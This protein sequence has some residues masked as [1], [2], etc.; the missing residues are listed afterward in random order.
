MTLR[1]GRFDVLGNLSV[2][3][4]AARDDRAIDVAINTTLRR[5]I[6]DITPPRKK[7][8]DDKVRRMATDL[9]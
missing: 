5:S 4:L 2:S 8:V 3:P 9:G 1:G 6:M 7:S